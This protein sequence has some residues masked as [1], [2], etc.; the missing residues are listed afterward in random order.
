MFLFCFMGIKM[1]IKQITSAQNGAFK[2]TAKYQNAREARKAGV[3][4]MEG[5]RAV[6]EVLKAADWQMESLWFSEELLKSDPPYVRAVLRV[7]PEQTP[8]YAVSA[9]LF[10]RLADTETPQGVLAV[11]KRKSFD[12]NQV[13]ASAGPN[14]LFVVLENLQDPGNVGT[15]LRT[16]DSAGAA[17]VV[18]TRGTADVY[19]PKVVRSAMGS[20]LHLPVCHAESVSAAA[21]IL[22]GAGLRLLAAHLQGKCYHFQQDMKGPIAILIGNEGAGLSAEATAQA[23]ALVKI[24]MLGQAESLNAAIAAGILIYEAVRQR[25]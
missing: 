25:I 18:C 22:R 2:Q 6:D 23:D 9:P 11:V 17:A 4:L 10:A 21:E 3:F 12:L 14:P 24:P 15:I 19:S 8:V 13:L 1:K 7:V 20:L 16:A 5:V